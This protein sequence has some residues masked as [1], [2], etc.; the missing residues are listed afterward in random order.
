MMPAK[1]ID[2]PTLHCYQLRFGPFVCTTCGATTDQAHVSVRLGRPRGSISANPVSPQ[3][4]P[5]H[6]LDFRLGECSSSREPGV[7]ATVIGYALSMSVHVRLRER[8]EYP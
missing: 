5:H 3:Q 2:L 1:P 8:F 6:P 4:S 7:K